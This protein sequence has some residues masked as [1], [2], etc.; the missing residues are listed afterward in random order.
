MVD[1]VS[2][3]VKLFDS[4]LVTNKNR[5]VCLEKLNMHFHNV[6]YAVFSVIEWK[7]AH[8]A[9]GLDTGISVHELLQ[10]G[11]SISE[12]DQMNVM[13]ASNRA[14]EYSA[15]KHRLD[16]LASLYL[17]K[18]MINNLCIVNILMSLQF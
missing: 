2:L 12:T 3:N 6:A 17:G 5:V 9:P 7:I 13:G 8:L 14:F 16:I 4:L 11:Q 15:A 10:I 18:D 1:S